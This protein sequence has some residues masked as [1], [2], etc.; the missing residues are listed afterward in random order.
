[1]CLSVCLSVTTIT[2]KIVDTVG[3]VIIRVWCRTKRLAVYLNA[4]LL[5]GNILANYHLPKQQLSELTSHP[6]TQTSLGF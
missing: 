4:R 5:T 2:K 3:S 1:M 6:T